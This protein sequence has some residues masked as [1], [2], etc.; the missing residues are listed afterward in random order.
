MFILICPKCESRQPTSE[1]LCLS[2]GDD[3]SSIQ[4]I[5]VM[6]DKL[7]LSSLPNSISPVM[8]QEAKTSARA[9]GEPEES[10]SKTQMDHHFAGEPELT[11]PSV[12]GIV[13]P[14][15]ECKCRK[16]VLPQN[17]GGELCCLSCGYP[18]RVQVTPDLTET[19]SVAVISPISQP[20][21]ERMV[22]PERP[23][24]KGVTVILPWG[25]RLVLAGL[26]VLG[27][28][29]HPDSRI[30]SLPENVRARLHR[31]FGTVSRFHLL[32]STQDGAVIA[33]SLEALN[34]AFIDGIPMAPGN[35]VALRLPCRLGLGGRCELIVEQSATTS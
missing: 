19:E 32:L 27:R 5:E 8:N 6:E 29:A 16:K 28:A 34:G 3:L 14:A 7:E 31:E 2:C 1:F 25:E 22:F 35:P 17:Q 24:T 18:I 13:R 4:A 9:G 15:R 26:L 23:S 10:S 12:Q 33:E 30:R 20:I 11:S 21:P